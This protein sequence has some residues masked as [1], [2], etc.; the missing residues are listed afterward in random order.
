MSIAESGDVCIIRELVILPEFQNRG[1]GSAIL[2]ASMDHA[3]RRGMAV[4]LEAL[5]ENRALKLY[6]RL[7]FREYGRNRTH[8]QMEW[9]G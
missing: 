2:R 5:R 7:G 9:I 6:E 4:R 8:I 3:A 1:I